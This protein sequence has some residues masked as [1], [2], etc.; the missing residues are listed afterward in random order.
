MLCVSYTCG[1]VNDL[2]T[3]RAGRIKHLAHR[4]SEISARERRARVCVHVCL[5]FAT[6]DR[7]H[8]FV[9]HSLRYT[10]PV[11]TTTSTSL[12]HG[13]MRVSFTLA[14]SRS[15]C[16]FFCAKQVTNCHTRAPSS[17]LAQR[18]QNV[19][20]WFVCVYIGLVS[21]CLAAFDSLQPQNCTHE[22]THDT[23]AI[24]GHALNPQY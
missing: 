2:L 23:H 9:S 1:D 21:L 5:A 11:C 3:G 17:T 16:S 10:C 13:C 24:K 18:H 12:A 4:G 22:N 19:C 7:R 14:L 6:R 8:R 20:W 15:F